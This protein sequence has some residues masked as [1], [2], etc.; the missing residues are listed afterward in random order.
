MRKLGLYWLA[1]LL[2]VSAGV[3]QATVF[4]NIRGIV[5]DPQHRPIQGANVTVKAKASDWT[6]DSND[7]CQWRVSAQRRTN[8]RIFSHGYQCWIRDLTAGRRR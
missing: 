6:E 2:L 5:H 1:A 3:A 7:R 8:R 4:G